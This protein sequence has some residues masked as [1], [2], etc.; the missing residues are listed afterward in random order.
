MT[1]TPGPASGANQ[2]QHERVALGEE[3]ANSVQVLPSTMKQM[4]QFMQ[5]YAAEMVEEPLAEVVKAVYDEG[6]AGWLPDFMIVDLGSGGASLACPERLAVGTAVQL[7]IQTPGT[8]D[9]TI[10]RGQVVRVGRSPG[11]MGGQSGLWYQHGVR[12][13]GA[14]EGP[15]N[16][17]MGLLRGLAGR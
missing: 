17:V 13:D 4:Y 9:A 2:R 3:Q 1:D 5:S 16:R 8:T 10:T 11:S 15:A 7:R 6:R 14:S 12:F